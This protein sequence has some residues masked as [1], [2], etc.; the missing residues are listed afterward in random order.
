MNFC[1]VFV[2]C[3][4]ACCSGMLYRRDADNVLKPDLQPVSSTV[5]PL[6]FY[7]VYGYEKKMY[8]DKHKKRPQGKIALVTKMP[9]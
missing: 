5:V 6:S 3:F 9:K 1:L 8:R 7:S 4:F 2:V